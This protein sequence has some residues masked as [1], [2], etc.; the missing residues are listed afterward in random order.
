LP[1]PKKPTHRRTA[2]SSAPSKVAA[3]SAAVAKLLDE[4]DRARDAAGL[5]KGALATAAGLPEASVRKLF[6]S[7][8]ANPALK[9]LFRLATPLGL[10]LTLNRRDD[11]TTGELGGRDAP[12]VED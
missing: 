8:T 5:T 6:T 11:L 4:L 1:S 7:R 10:Q 2:G 3:E 12:T 9:T